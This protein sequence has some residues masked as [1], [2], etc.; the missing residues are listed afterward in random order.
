MACLR[1]PSSKLRLMPT[2]PLWPLLVS[3]LL[4]S[5]S[6]QINNALRSLLQLTVALHLSPAQRSLPQSPNSLSQDMLC[7]VLSSPSTNVETAIR[8]PLR[9]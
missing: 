2:K 3:L 9:T 6:L 5:P 4:A 7:L 1:T 8:A